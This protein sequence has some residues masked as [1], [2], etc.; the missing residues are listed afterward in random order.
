MIENWKSYLVTMHE[1][2]FRKLAC[3]PDND[4]YPL[5]ELWEGDQLGAQ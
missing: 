3:S 2:I 5:E 1:S 4:L